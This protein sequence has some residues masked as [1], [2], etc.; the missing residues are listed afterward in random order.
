L[1]A[2]IYYRLS[3]AVVPML[4]V[5]LNNMRFVFSYDVT[6]SA[7]SK[8][9]NYRGATEFSIIKKGFYPDHAD[10]KSMCPEF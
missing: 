3:D 6:L 1:I 2:G 9:N 7:L 5:E 8:Y 10:R 4:G